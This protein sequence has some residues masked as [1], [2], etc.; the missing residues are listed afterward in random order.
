VGIEADLDD[1]D[2]EEK[3]RIDRRILSV[4]FRRGSA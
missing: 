2:R 4:A 3:E 1:A